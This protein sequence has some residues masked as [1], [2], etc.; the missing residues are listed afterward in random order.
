MTAEANERIIDLLERWSMSHKP[1]VEI[2]GKE[3]AGKWPL[4]QRQRLRL[5]SHEMGRTALLKRS[6]LP[7]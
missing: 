4:R 3:N 5:G 6:F 1:D 2:D 7:W